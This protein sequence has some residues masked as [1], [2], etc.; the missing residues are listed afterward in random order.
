MGGA[1]FFWIQLGQVW[2]FHGRGQ[3]VGKWSEMGEGGAA[4][5]RKSEKDPY[6]F[7]RTKEFQNFNTFSINSPLLLR[8]NT[9]CQ[10]P[11]VAVNSGT[12]TTC[13]HNHSARPNS[14]PVAWSYS[15]D[16]YYLKSQVTVAALDVQGSSIISLWSI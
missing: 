15:G 1:L 8:T 14:S 3:Q 6:E 5:T 7:T 2:Q 13:N 12:S 10:S 4:G 9:Y 16:N 11:Q